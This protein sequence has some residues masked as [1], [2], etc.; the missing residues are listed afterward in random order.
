MAEIVIY[1]YGHRPSRDK[2]ITTHVALTSRAMG[3]D[4]MMVDTGDRALE[5]NIKSVN[6]NFGGD[7]KVDT[8]VSL[9]TFLNNITKEDTLIHLTMYGQS[10]EDRISEIKKKLN[11]DGRIF[12]FVGAEKV[13]GII[14]SKSNFNIS[15]T[16]QP[17]SEV[18]A[19]GL[20]LDRLKDGKELDLR[21]KGRLDILPQESGKNIEFYPDSK[22]CMEILLRHKCN[23]KLIE[24]SIAVQE[25]A[26]NICA[27]IKCDKRIVNAASLLHDVGRTVDNGVKHSYEGYI[28]CKREKISDKVSSAVLKHTGAGI[29]R[30]ESKRLFL[31]DLDYMPETLEEKIVACADNL[32]KGDGR[33]DIF[34]QIK[35]YEEKGLKEPA[36][37]ILELYK[38]ISQKAGFDINLIEI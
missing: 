28:I 16:N 17:I 10:V 27:G 30:E 23:E 13:P 33:V 7:F 12:I 38:F 25:V 3:A 14:Y 32:I 15:I 19:L 26:M 22:D 20:F 31:P 5:E 36:G 18:S 21:L 4:Y 37:R 8:G 6:R 11:E 35:R 34:D 29:T 1:R 9:N 2:R 24:H